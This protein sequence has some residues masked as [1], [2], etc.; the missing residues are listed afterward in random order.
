M[1]GERLW[2]WQSLNIVEREELVEQ[3]ETDSTSLSCTPLPTLTLTV[4][5]QQY[6][7]QDWRNISIVHSSVTVFCSEFKVSWITNLSVISEWWMRGWKLNLSSNVIEKR[8]EKYYSSFIIP[9][10]WKSTSN[11]A[12]E[13]NDWKCNENEV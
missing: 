7:R 10:F 12:P 9:L 4:Q 6:F 1:L 13:E 5:Q 3:C 2:P 8:K 11:N